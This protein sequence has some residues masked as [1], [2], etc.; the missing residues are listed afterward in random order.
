[1][2]LQGEIQ[3]LVIFW[4]PA[5]RVGQVRT[6]CRRVLDLKKRFNFSGGC[7]HIWESYT[8]P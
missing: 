2:S 8:V 4:R 5:D 1:M 3:R 7:A 6:V